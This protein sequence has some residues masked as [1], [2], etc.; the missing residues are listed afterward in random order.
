MFKSIVRI[1]FMNEATIRKWG[2]RDYASTAKRKSWRNATMLQK[3][4]M[5]TGRLT[6]K[7]VLNIWNSRRLYGNRLLIGLRTINMIEMTITITRMQRVYPSKDFMKL[8]NLFVE[9]KSK[10]I[11]Q[12][13]FKILTFSTYNFKNIIQLRYLSSLI[14]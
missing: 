8:L 6:H 12:P 10:H 9:I 5:L 13:L 11:C 2:L 14:F 4:L 1:A 3:E 7:Y